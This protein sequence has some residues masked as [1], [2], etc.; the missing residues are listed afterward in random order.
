MQY[1]DLGTWRFARKRWPSGLRVP[2]S[3]A[4]GAGVHAFS[5]GFRLRFAHGVQEPS[6]FRMPGWPRR[7]LRTN[8]VCEDRSP[9]HPWLLAFLHGS[10]TPW[11]R[12]PPVRASE[13]KV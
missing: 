10:M 1:H 9:I 7:S 12:L 8:Y 2:D 3:A 11:T 4:G 5:I 6:T 13:E